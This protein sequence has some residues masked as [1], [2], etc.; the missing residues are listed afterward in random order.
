MSPPLAAVL[1]PIGVVLVVIAAGFALHSW[2][3]ARTRVRTTATITEN[4]SGFAKE[5]DH[6]LQRVGAIE[7]QVPY[8]MA[9]FDPWSCPLA[10]T[11]D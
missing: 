7:K 10:Y 11:P 5:I 2:N 4:V 9:L 8:R 1:P 3:F 6:L